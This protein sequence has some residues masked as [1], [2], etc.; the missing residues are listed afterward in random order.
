MT[1]S[2]GGYRP[3]RPG[4]DKDMLRCIGMTLIIFIPLALVLWLIFK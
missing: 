4:S 2:K 1:N 3:G